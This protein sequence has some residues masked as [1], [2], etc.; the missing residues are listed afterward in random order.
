M[1]DRVAAVERLAH[2]RRVGE[3]ADHGLDLGR[4]VVGRGDQVD[5]PRLVACGREL[6]DDV[7]AD[8]PGAAGDES[9]HRR[10]YPETAWSSAGTSAGR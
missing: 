4:V 3:V 6:V 7:R 1:E 5:D 10:S 2:G 9:L 8:E